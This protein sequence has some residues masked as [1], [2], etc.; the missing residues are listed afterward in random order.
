MCS[1]DGSNGDIPKGEYN[2]ENMK[3][4][5]VENRNIIFSAIIYG[6][7]LGW[8]NKTK[9]N[10]EITLGIHAGDHACY[11]DTTKESQEAA[12]HCF[13]ISNWGSERVDYRAPFVEITK[14]KVLK[15]GIDAMKKLQFNQKEIDEVLANTHSCY[16]PDEKGRSCGLCGT[17]IEENQKVLM[18]DNTWKKIKDVQIGDFV[19]G[20][21]ENTK[22][23]QIAEVLDKFDNG[24]K[25]VY[26]MNGL[27]LTNNHKVYASNK[28][29]R[30]MFRE[31]KH[32]NRKDA[33]Y[34]VK[35]WPVE[36]TRTDVNEEEFALGYLRGFADGGGS[37]DERGIHVVQKEETVLIEFWNLYNKYISECHVSVKWD[38]RRNMFY[39]SGGYIPTFFEK[40]KFNLDSDEYLRG[41]LNGILISDGGAFYNKS[42]KS[43][44][45]GI[46]QSIKV[47]NSI[48]DNIQIALDKLNIKHD[49]YQAK[50]G[51]FKKEGTLMCEWRITRPYKIALK[52]G[53]MK[54]ENMLSKLAK[55]NTVKLLSSS[56]VDKIGDP[57]SNSRV[58]DIKTNTG[59]FICEGYLV[60]NCKERIEA[61]QKNGLKDPVEYQVPI[62]W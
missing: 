50:C 13:E 43:F 33:T 36:F 3:S 51:G 42:N 28:N 44:G 17:C 59:T 34:M 25:E 35:R 26:D 10:V 38:D 16:D 58:Y 18:A 54:K 22:H 12:K 53:T 20:V 6:K 4:T 47:N 2:E 19:W 40:T 9:E 37:Y 30:P 1:A 27:L 60:H 11:R 45:Y 55:Y 48:C 24:I 8:A 52:Y 49:F 23:I 46:S 7:A 39:G 57:I 61:F 14:D 31:Y 56:K 32:M 62:N 5:V 21:D 29:T 41:Y 15:E